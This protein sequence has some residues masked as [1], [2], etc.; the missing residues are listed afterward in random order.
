MGAFSDEIRKRRSERQLSVRQLA[1]A[2][3]KTPGYLS[4]IEARGEIPTP[5]LVCQIAAVLETNAERLLELAKADELKQFKTDLNSR[6]ESAL[7]LY[8]KGRNANPR[9]S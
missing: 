4:R 9:P 2:V 8:R 3:G 5:E 6:H 7:L 1:A